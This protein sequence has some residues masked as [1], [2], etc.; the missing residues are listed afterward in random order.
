MGNIEKVKAIEKTKKML[1]ESGAA[2]FIYSDDNEEM[3]ILFEDL[4]LIKTETFV[5]QDNFKS[6]EIMD[7]NYRSVPLYD[8][9][10]DEVE[11]LVK[12]LHPFSIFKVN[13]TKTHMINQ[14]LLKNLYT[15]KLTVDVDFYECDL[16][17]MEEIK[18]HVEINKQGTTK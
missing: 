14:D 12:S 2:S 4:N 7:V 13:F 10:S 15:Y 9:L 11:N 8:P 5:V 1:V 16:I 18:E 17:D 3:E 6:E